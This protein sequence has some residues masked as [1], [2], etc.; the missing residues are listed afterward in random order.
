MLTFRSST[1]AKFRDAHLGAFYKVEAR[2]DDDERR[3]RARNA[4]LAR[5]RPRLRQRPRY[6][7][8]DAKTTFRSSDSSAQVVAYIAP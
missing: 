6:A 4:V 8:F 3:V 1:T 2:H 7:D 5:V